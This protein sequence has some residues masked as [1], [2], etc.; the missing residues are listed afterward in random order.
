MNDFIFHVRL[1]QYLATV[2]RAVVLAALRPA[3]P[4]PVPDDL[5]LA[6]ERFQACA[7]RAAISVPWA[8]KV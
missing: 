1:A 4:A 7:A 6:Y 3:P 5:T 8:R 2:T